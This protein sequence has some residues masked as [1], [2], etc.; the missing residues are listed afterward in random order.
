MGTQKGGERAEKTVFW[1][2]QQ[3]WMKGGDVRSEC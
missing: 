3:Y 2:D 1:A